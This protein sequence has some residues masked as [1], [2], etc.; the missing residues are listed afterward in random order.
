M[1]AYVIAKKGSELLD[2][3]VFRA[4]PSGGEEA[5]AVFTDSRRAERYIEQAGWSSGHEVGQLTDVQLLRWAVRIHEDGVQYLA[6]NPDRERQLANDQLEIIVIEEQLASFAE[7]LT[8]DIL[9]S[10][11]SDAATE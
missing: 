7:S 6:V 3:P 8:H 2:T 11:Q 9:D 10:A 5:V 1:S 4:G